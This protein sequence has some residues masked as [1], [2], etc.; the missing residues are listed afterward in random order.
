MKTELYPEN[1]NK[2]AKTWNTFK[3]YFT[4]EHRDLRLLRTSA[5]NIGY[6][7]GF[8]VY[9]DRT[10]SDDNNN[11]TDNEEIPANTNDIVTALANTSNDDNNTMSSTLQE[12]TFTLKVLQNKVHNL[13][14]SGKNRKQ[15]K[16]NICYYWTHGRTRNNN[17]TSQS[18]NNKKEE[19]Q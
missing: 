9:E 12:L 19:H 18:C 8:N 3:L 17:H 5:G 11:N 1:R 7:V 10:P 15:N 14:Q 16:N 2:S 6:R 4:K 13:D